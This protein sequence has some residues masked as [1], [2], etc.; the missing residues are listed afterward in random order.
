MC[1]LQHDLRLRV[2]EYKYEYV[3]H[4]SMFQTSALNKQKACECWHTATCRDAVK[5][6]TS[7]IY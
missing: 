7:A 1:T 4:G 3:G 6:T 2:L 5:E